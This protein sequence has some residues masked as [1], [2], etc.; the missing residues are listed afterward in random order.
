YSSH[1]LD[2]NLEIKNQRRHQ[3]VTR[4]LAVNSGQCPPSWYAGSMFGMTGCLAL[5][6]NKSDPTPWGYSTYLCRTLDPRAKMVTF[7]SVSQFTQFK[8]MAR[9]LADSTFH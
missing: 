8:T 1:N 7:K 5:M 9:A 2:A 6:P 4:P 3:L